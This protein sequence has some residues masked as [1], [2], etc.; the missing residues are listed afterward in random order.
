MRPPRVRMRDTTRRPSPADV[1]G[2]LRILPISPPRK[3]ADSRKRK[4]CARSAADFRGKP[5]DPAE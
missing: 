3:S 4:R 5:R 1:R 2:T